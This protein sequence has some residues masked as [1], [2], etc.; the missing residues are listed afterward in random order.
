MGGKNPLQGACTQPLLWQDRHRGLHSA[1]GSW[2]QPE[3]TLQKPSLLPPS[4][5]GPTHVFTKPR[6]PWELSWRSERT[7][8][9][10]GHLGLCCLQSEECCG[11]GV[12][13]ACLNA[14][15]GPHVTGMWPTWS[16]WRIC[17]SRRC[18]HWL[19]GDTVVPSSGTSG[20]RHAVR[21]LCGRMGH[22]LRFCRAS[23]RPATLA[24]KIRCGPALSDHQNTG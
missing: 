4:L 7:V 23:Y 2:L 10:F 3:V 16:D 21:F 5:G 19:R 15:P 17:S 8:E 18:L 6:D 13:E 20:G 24:W 9:V 12:T 1:P 22:W 11:L 14:W